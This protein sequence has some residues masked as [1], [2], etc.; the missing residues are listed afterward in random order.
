MFHE[1]KDV[2]QEPG[3][4]RR[5]WFESDHFDLVV[6]LEP[7]ERIAG[8]QLCYDFGRGERALTWREGG[9]FAHN[10]VDTGTESP[11]KNCTPILV[12]DGEVPWSE[13]TSR[14]T[15]RSGSLEPALRDFVLT[16]LQSSRLR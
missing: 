2:K 6:W 7:D 8:F 12:A 15:A 11:F 3:P 16:K 1:I 5:R 10:M 9:G 14:F 4:G 13:V